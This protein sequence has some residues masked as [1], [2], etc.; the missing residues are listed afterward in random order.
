MRVHPLQISEKVLRVLREEQISEEELQHMLKHAAI[1]RAGGCNW[2]FHHWGFLIEHQILK[3]MRHVEMVEVGQ[4]EAR[5][6]EEHE[7]C[8][9]E[10]CRAC[11][12]CG[13]LIRRID[14]AT[15]VEIHR[16]S[17]RPTHRSVS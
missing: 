13:Q 6:Y 4:G 14:D 10:G 5:V 11:G 17:V 8:H 7:P 3:D 1:S 16:E 9:G 12:W 15:D 2:R